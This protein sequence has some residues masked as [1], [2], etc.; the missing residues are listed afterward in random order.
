MSFYFRTI[1]NFEYV[2][3]SSD[4]SISDYIQIKNLFKK[5]KLREDIFGSLVYFTKYNVI[6]NERPDQ[7]AEKFYGDE[8]LDWVIL[9]SN[10]ILDVRSEWPLDNQSFD[11]AL[12]EKY[13]SY[14]ILHG[15][16]HHYETIEVKNSAGITIIPAGLKMTPTWKTNGNFIEFNTQ[17]IS[18]IFAGNGV[19]PTTTVTVTMNG[20]IKG[21]KIDDQIIIANISEAAF[22]GVFKVTSVYVPFDDG[23]TRSFTY[24]LLT[25]PGISQPV[26]STSQKEEVSTAVYDSQISGNA[27]YFEYYD[28]GSMTRL[29]SSSILTEVT[30]YDY[31]LNLNNKKREIYILK[32][33]YL[34]I[35]LNDAEAASSYKTG[36]VQYVND[37][38]KRGDNVRIYS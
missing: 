24:E 27:Y 37:T 33:T 20:G 14:E 11:N 17:K 16:I 30:N 34:G 26:M 3:P 31:E 29:S 12:L 8:T 19:T 15:G 4:A 21:L 10:N 36:G 28:Q 9:F 38:L 1:P 32:P 6:G 5:G 13:G 23:I 2:N 25:T 22:N 35:I 18:Q 7:I